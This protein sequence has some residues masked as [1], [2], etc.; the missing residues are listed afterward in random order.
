MRRKRNRPAAIV[1]ILLVIF[2]A[3]LIFLFY[4]HGE[5]SSYKDYKKIIV[6]R[7]VDGDTF[8][9]EEND[10][11]IKVRLIGIDTPE[12]VAPKESGK[13]NTI[14]GSIAS[15]FTKDL[16][17]SNNGILYLEY[18]KEKYDKYGRELAYAYLED[19]R[20]V[21]DILLLE[22]YA[23]LMTIEPNTKYAKRFSKERKVKTI[24]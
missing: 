2:M 23:D 20:M 5:R 14:E 18:D 9:Y 4:S 11:E 6:T 7:V 3:L 8:C 19:G 10:E 22:G 1:S 21:Q 15:V 24:K 13:T 17:F 12:S 16:I